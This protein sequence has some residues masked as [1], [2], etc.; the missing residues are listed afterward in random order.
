MTKESLELRLAEYQQQFD[1]TSSEIT[2]HENTIISLRE[3]ALII[4]GRY[5][6]IQDQLKAFPTPTPE[7]GEIIK[8]K[9]ASRAESK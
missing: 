8:K 3:Q 5:L 4:K 2:Q 9:V 7:E 1:S 6:E